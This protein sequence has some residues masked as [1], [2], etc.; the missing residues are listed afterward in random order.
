MTETLDISVVIPVYNEEEN[1][2][3]L[4]EQLSAALNELGKSY[5]VIVVDD[6]SK[7]NSFER[8]KEVH[9]KDSRWQIIR[10]RRNFGQTAGM[11]AGFNASRGD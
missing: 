5:E 6:G 3:L 4:Y 9:E 10:F 11:S 2:P 8:L 7:D 1:I